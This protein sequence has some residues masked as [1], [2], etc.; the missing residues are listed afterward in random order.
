MTAT[1]V[2]QVAD[3]LLGS[4]YEPGGPVEITVEDGCISAI[5]PLAEPSSGPRR[6]AMPALADAH[7]HARP[8][9]TTSFGCG[10]KPLETWL[11]SLAAMP[12]VDP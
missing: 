9:S 2:F 11:P 10:L 4:A 1:R 8:L 3:A 12:S 6:L 5:Q 7:N